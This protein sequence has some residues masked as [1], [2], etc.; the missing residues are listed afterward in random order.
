MAE[1]ELSVLI[2]QCLNRRIPD[3]AILHPVVTAWAVR[4]KAGGT[5]DWR[6]ATADV[7]INLRCHYSAVH[8]QRGASRG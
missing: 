6:F 5:V 4:R 3:R 7:R 1:I 8:A 2:R